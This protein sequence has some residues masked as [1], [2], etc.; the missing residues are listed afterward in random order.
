M[1]VNTNTNV[2]V[3]EQQGQPV[4]IGF[5]T[6]MLLAGVVALFIQYWYIWVPVLATGLALW[7]TRRALMLE[8]QRKQALAARA[9][10]QT[11]WLIQ[12]DPRG[13]YG[14]DMWKGLSVNDY[15]STHGDNHEGS[16]L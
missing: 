4:V 2:V 5:F 1:S 12:G 10:Q 9:D 6:F 11:D 16:Q 8:A 13:I 14:H 15:R 3:V 7:A